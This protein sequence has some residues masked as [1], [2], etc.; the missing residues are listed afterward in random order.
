M[1]IQKGLCSFTDPE[2]WVD[3]LDENES[4]NWSILVMN[5]LFVGWMNHFERERDLYHPIISICWE[6]D[7]FVG[8]NESIWCCCRV[9]LVI[10]GCKKT[11]SSLSYSL[12]IYLV[13]IL[14][15]IWLIHHSFW[16]DDCNSIPVSSIV[17]AVTRNCLF[18][19][20]R[21]CVQ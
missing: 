17:I 5:D 4:W 11:R 9:F 19:F 1:L 8:T 10:H 6:N 20:P 3:E 7:L 12:F 2:L 21:N 16:D 13:K 14:I 18:S 15:V